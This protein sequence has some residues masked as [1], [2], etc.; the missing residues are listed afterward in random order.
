[1]FPEVSIGGARDIRALATRAAKGGRLQP[2]DLLLVL[3]MLAASRNLRRAV[4]RLPE[5]TTRFPQ[6]L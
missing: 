5:V 3:D 2:G 6:I 4:L 1:M